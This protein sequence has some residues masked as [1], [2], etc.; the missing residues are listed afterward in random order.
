MI[1]NTRNR[2]NDTTESQKEKKTCVNAH[3][4]KI[5][6]LNKMWSL[7]S[8]AVLTC[9]S[10]TSLHMQYNVSDSQALLWCVVLI[11]LRMASLDTLFLVLRDSNPGF[12]I[13]LVLKFFAKAKAFLF[14]NMFLQ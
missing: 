6:E 8:L 2:S 5:T 11:N 1:Y 12:V 14:I 9:E 10:R 7:K 3:F 4:Q 13:T